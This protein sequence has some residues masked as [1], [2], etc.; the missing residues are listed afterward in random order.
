MGSRRVQSEGPLGFGADEQETQ[1]KRKQATITGDLKRTFSP[2]FLNRVDET[3]YFHSLGRDEIK[4]IVDILLREVSY[5]LRNLNISFDFKPEAKD[6]L[7]DMGFDPKQG[8]RPLRRSIQKH[9]EDPLSE[10]LLRGEIRSHCRLVIGAAGGR[11]SFE[12]LPEE[13]VPR[14]KV[15][16]DAGTDTEDED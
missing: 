1:D 14:E 3:V 11:L 13:S 9:L 12:V 5:R 7:C 10:R 4:Q 2:E 8:A 16:P 6:F 15:P